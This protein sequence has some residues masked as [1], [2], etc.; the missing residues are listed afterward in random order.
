MSFS[1]SENNQGDIVNEWLQAVH[2]KKL[3]GIAHRIDTSYKCTVMC[4]KI[5]KTTN[6]HLAGRW[7]NP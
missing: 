7:T 4:N 6:E 2:K 5:W 3:T 1:L